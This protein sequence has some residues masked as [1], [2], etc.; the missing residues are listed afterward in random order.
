MTEENLNQ[1]LTLQ[2]DNITE[3]PSPTVAIVQQQNQN[4]PSP[5][6]LVSKSASEIKSEIKKKYYK[7]IKRMIGGSFKINFNSEYILNFKK[8][9]D[10]VIEKEAPLDSEFDLIQFLIDRKIIREKKVYVDYLESS[11]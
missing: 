11:N 5:P 6:Q 1:G 3:A 8:F 10:Y 4:S 2:K 7:T 9:L